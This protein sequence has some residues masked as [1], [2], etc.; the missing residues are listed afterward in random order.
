[1]LCPH[2][3]EAPVTDLQ[4]SIRLLPFYCPYEPAIHPDV[5]QIRQ[6]SVE[7]LDRMGFYRNELHRAWILTTDA[8][9]AMS[10]IYPESHQDAVSLSACWLLLVFALDDASFDMPGQTLRVSDA[11]EF[12]ARLMRTMEAPGD[13]ALT[14]VVLA[15]AARNIVIT[16]EGIATPT[17]IRRYV[18]A[19]RHWLLAI[20]WKLSITE[21]APQLDL[22]TYTR[23][24]LAECGGRLTMAW[25]EIGHGIEIPGHDLDNP[26][27][28]A[29]AEAA[30]LVMGWDNDFYSYHRE[31]LR[32]DSRHHNIITVLAR[33]NHCPPHRAVADAVAMRDRAMTLFVRLHQQLR[34]TVS[35]GMRYYLD[36]LGHAIRC[37]ID[38]GGT[39]GRNTCLNARTEMPRRGAPLDITVVGHPSNDCAE[40]L[41]MPSVSWWWNHLNPTP[42]RS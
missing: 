20:L 35:P 23:M 1:M 19:W 15:E 8:A 14:G 6:R 2:P 34:P 11:V 42:T 4:D 5:D 7:W 32:G 31:G 22:D 40:P 28:Q 17:Q 26:A 24:R 39:C 18:D 27:V 29:A 10:Q 3:S 38:W 21:S 33:H 30:F 25:S 41:A 9:E 16:L 12:I 36:D 37:N 13:P